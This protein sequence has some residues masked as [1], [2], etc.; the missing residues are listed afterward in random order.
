M[1]YLEKVLFTADDCQNIKNISNK[2]DKAS[3]LIKTNDGYIEYVNE[4]KRYNT[5]TYLTLKRGD[6][7][8]DKIN[9]SI[10]LFGYEFLID[11]LDTG[12][13]RYE[14][15]NFIF[16]HN[17]LPAEGIDRFFCIIVQLNQSYDYD[18]GDFR[19]YINNTPILMKR[20]IGNILIFNP[21]VMHEVTMVNS[22]VRHSMVI[23][24][25]YSQLK[26]DKKTSL[27]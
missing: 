9:E 3:L 20:D 10:K 14:T 19:Y 12:I 2:F 16:K 26:S 6:G 27:I 18:G 11:E 22:G 24:V 17:D 25:N 7:I 8:F 4:K 23:W 15:G 21:N 13:L 1:I 5:A